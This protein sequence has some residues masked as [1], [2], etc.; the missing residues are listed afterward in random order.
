MHILCDVRSKI[1][2][3][4]VRTPIQCRIILVLREYTS[5]LLRRTTSKGSIGIYWLTI[6]RIVRTRD[7]TVWEK[8]RG[9]SVE[10]GSTDNNS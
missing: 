5:G 9:F 2:Y 8:C 3:L 6:L 1:T 7:Y 10:P 4:F